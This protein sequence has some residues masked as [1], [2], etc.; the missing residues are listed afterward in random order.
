MRCGRAQ[1]WMAAA[2]DGELSS[3]RRHTLDRHLAGCASCQ[4]EMVS[5]ERMLSAV[6]ALPAEVEVPAR[7]EQ[8]TLRRVRLLAA[9]EAERRPSWWQAVRL[10]MF[11]VATMAVLALA[12]GIVRETGAPT[13]RKIDAQ[14]A[15]SP[16]PEP[17][18]PEVVAQQEQA[19]APA[20][21]PAADPPAE[22]ALRPD[23]FVDMP[24]LRNMEKLRNFDAIQTTT[25]E[26]DANPGADGDEEDN[27]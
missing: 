12:V 2:V 25:V 7:L 21:V 13:G 16:A 23:L 22:L 8:A 27:G 15:K 14:T 19:P 6:A 20:A 4:Q 1:Q 24:I 9:E 3:R 5:T 10:P 11:A 26:D 18:T 17:A